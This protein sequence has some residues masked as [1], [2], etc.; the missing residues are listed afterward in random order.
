M[1][2]FGLFSLLLFLPLLDVEVMRNMGSSVGLYFQKFQF[3]ASFYYLIR[4]VGLVWIGRETGFQF[5]PWLS[6]VVLI[7]VLFLAFLL[8]KKKI[9]FIDSLVFASFVQL[10]FSSTVHPWY[11]IL[12]FGIALL[13]NWRFP[14]FWTGLVALSYSHYQGGGLQEN[15]VLIGLEYAVL[16]LVLAVEVRA[17]H[18]QSG[19]PTNLHK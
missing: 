6:L 10:S 11:V 12:P 15:F 4:A 2:L 8:Y 16:W 3:N 18:L 14:L 13:S 1:L 17:Q 9:Q 7:C 19:S 5:G